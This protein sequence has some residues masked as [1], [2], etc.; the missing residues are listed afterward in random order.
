MKKWILV[1]V[2]AMVTAGFVFAQNYTV[3]SVTGFVQ[4]EAGGKR[5]NLRAGELL[6]ADTVI[7]IAAEASLV[8]KFGERMINIPSARS[9]RVADLSSTGSGLRIGGN[10]SRV[11]TTTTSRV[12]GQAITA[13]ARASD[14]ARDDDIS[15]E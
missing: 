4:K 1:L 14:A 15:A 12:S 3:E 9:G 2:M 5:E 10:V 7:H 6:N 11:D 13:S 8:L